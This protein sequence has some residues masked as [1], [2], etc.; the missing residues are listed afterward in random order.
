MEYAKVLID[1]DDY[2][3]SENQI[4][5]SSGDFRLERR[6]KRRERELSNKCRKHNHHDSGTRS[7]IKSC[8]N[9]AILSVQEGPTSED[10]MDEDYKLFLVE[11]IPDEIVVVSDGNVD[12]SNN[13]INTGNDTA[14][15]DDQYRMFLEE[16]RFRDDPRLDTEMMK[17]SKERYETRKNGSDSVRKQLSGP[18]KSQQNLEARVSK[19]RPREEVPVVPKNNCHTE[20][21]SSKQRDETRN[22]AY[23]GNDS[24]Q[25]QTSGSLKSHQIL[26]AKRGHS[27]KR[28]F[29]DVSGVPK[30][31][32]HTEMTR[33][34]KRSNESGNKGSD[35]VRKQTRGTLNSQQNLEDIRGLSRERPYED[36]S[37]MP[38]NNCHSNMELDVVDEDYQI[39]L[40]CC[41]DG[42]IPSELMGKSPSVLREGDE[43]YLQYLDSL[44]IVDEEECLPERN[45][46]NT[47][48][49]R[50]NTTKTDMS[51]R[52][53]SKTNMS[54]NNTT[55]TG[56][57]EKN[58]SKTD[59]PKRNTSKTDMLE[60]NTS[61]TNM[62]KRNSSETDMSKR[63]TLDSGI[64]DR[65]TSK[66]NM[67]KSL[68]TDI[69]E[70]NISNPD[71]HERNISD[72]VNVDGDSNSSEPDLILLEP[73]Q[74][75]ENTPFVSSK[76][77]D[78]SVSVFN[79]TNCYCIFHNHGSQTFILNI[80]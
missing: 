24:V 44:R 45:T 53:I 12:G 64:P 25:K 74:I 66:I 51:E 52:N 27:K 72:T 3:I 80:F 48:M 29:E 54:K 36:A 26:E 49:S 6:W 35:S 73:D 23:K 21:K 46:S 79:F 57:S 18:I 63:K 33:A 50:R 8:G 65:N 55:K 71:I 4:V 76:A 30:P 1:V 56:M 19:K 69:P 15:Y 28:P 75:H 32:C 39:F 38:E 62:P 68:H 40:N 78:S 58:T 60:K 2:E 70:R 13:D 43:D 59:M 5:P 61:K 37:V 11:Y 67:P 16:E 10:E 20:T 47:N 22:Q 77:Y 34:A 9:V 7:T 42:Y 41:V 31:N 17:S 14:H